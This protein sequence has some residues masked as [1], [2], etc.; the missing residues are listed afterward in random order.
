MAQLI[1]KDV[2]LGYEN[3]TLAKNLN[4]EVNKGDYLCIVGENGTG[5]STLIK[6][7]LHLRRPLAGSIHYSDGLS[8][9]DVGYLPQ[10]TVVQ[11]DFPASV[12]EIVV[13]GFQGKMGLRPFYSK[14]ER[15]GARRA[16]KRL[17]IENL[18][19]MSYMELSGGQQQRVLL[20]RALCAA[21]KLLLLD[22]P[23]TGLDPYGANE[24][25]R[26]IKSLNDEGISIIMITHDVQAA[27]QFA[28]HILHIGSTVFF[29]TREQYMQ[30]REGLRYIRFHEEEEREAENV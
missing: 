18:E 26:T 19:N 15:E 20:A 21:D 29:G 11:K 22:E 14:E 5:K 10:Q 3:I 28:T 1:C 12:Y 4:F 23:A 25:Y 27:L 7:I 16:M 13:S 2:T 9:R 8:D 30:S 17:G 24:M 6:T